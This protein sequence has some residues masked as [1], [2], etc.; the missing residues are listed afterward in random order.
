MG[1]KKF[2][3]QFDEETGENFKKKCKLYNISM[4]VVIQGLM[5]DFLNGDY[6]IIIS[7]NNIKLCRHNTETTDKETIE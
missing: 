2:N 7:Q 3:F 4:S 5:C 6:D 1:L